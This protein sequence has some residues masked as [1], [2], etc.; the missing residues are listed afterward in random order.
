MGPADSQIDL[1]IGRIY[2]R[3]ADAGDV[4]KRLS[5]TEQEVSRRAGPPSPRRHF[6]CRP[7]DPATKLKKEHEHER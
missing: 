6:R 3:A 7:D 5:G 2:G 4:P 1:A